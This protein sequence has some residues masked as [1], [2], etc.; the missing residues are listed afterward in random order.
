MTHFQKVSLFLLRVGLGWVFFW[1]GLSHLRTPGWS[2]AGYLNSA[3]TFP[4]LFHW[5]ASSGLLPATN[6]IAEWGL[7]LLGISLIFG[8]FVRYTAWFGVVLMALFYFPVLKFP[9]PNPN[10]FIVDEHIIYI[11]ALL[12]L[13]AFRSDRYWAFRKSR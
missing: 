2:A 6:L 7:L 8:I 13:A 5:F 3:K 11:G 4:A 12:V 1:A 10:S 9:Y